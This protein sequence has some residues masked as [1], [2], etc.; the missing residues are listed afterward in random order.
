MFRT[1]VI[2]IL[3]YFFPVIPFLADDTGHFSSDAARIVYYVIVWSP[4][5]VFIIS[6]VLAIKEVV[7]YIKTSKV[8]DKRASLKKAFFISAAFFVV[9][10]GIVL[11]LIFGFPTFLI[12]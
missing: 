4:L 12:N 9:I 5:I 8:A 2:L 6:W 3:S 10:I 11:G 1:V 7:Y